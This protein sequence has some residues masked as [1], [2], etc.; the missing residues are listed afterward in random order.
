LHFN[1]SIWRDP[2]RFNPDRFLDRTPT[3][4]EYVPFGGGYRRCPGAAFAHNELTIAIGTIMGDVDLTVSRTERRRKPPRAVPRG[5]ATVPHREM[6]LE[7]SSTRASNPRRSG[8]PP[9]EKRWPG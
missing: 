3:P 4:F 5:I 2:E 7:V 9:S 8:H 6:T 1:P